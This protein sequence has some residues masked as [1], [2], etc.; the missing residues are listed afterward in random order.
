[1]SSLCLFLE[2]IDAAA[3]SGQEGV[4]LYFKEQLDLEI[5]SISFSIVQFYN[6]A[7]TGDEYSTFTCRQHTCRHEKS[8]RAESF[9]ASC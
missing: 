4:L 3:A 6:A 2:V 9:M 5:A 8:Q 7:K 1:M